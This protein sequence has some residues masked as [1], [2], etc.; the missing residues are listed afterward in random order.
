VFVARRE[1]F[2]HVR[3]V[4]SNTPW[5]ALPWQPEQMLPYVP[6]PATNGLGD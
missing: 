1:G 6:L 5:P 3:E 2:I 4:G